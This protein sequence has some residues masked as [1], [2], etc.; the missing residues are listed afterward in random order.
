[1]EGDRPLI[2]AQS[3]ALEEV[4]QAKSQRLPVSVPPVD[5]EPA[6]VDA[7]ATHELHGL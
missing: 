3:T 1:L 6:H 5:G 4:F 2:V 7:I